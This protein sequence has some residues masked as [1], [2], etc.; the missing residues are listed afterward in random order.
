[1]G[2][3]CCCWAVHARRWQAATLP[4]QRP[5]SLR[6]PPAWPLLSSSASND[7]SAPPVRWQRN[8]RLINR[9]GN[10][11]LHVWMRQLAGRVHTDEAGLLSRSQQKLLRVGQ[12]R[13]LIEVQSHTGG[14][15]GDRHDAID[16]AIR[17]RV[18]DDDGVVVVVRQLVCG[19]ES[20]AYSSPD[21][22][23]E[24]LILRIKPVDEGPELG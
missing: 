21:R 9:S 24:L 20:L 1:M 8:P 12:P 7:E 10:H 4:Q 3:A 5:P 14:T 22:S 16:P 23:N 13:S 6:R 19:R 18:T 2:V 11:R 17:R 15:C